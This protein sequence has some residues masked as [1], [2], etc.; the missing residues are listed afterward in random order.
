M[1][2]FVSPFQLRHPCRLA[3]YWEEA[4]FQA[5]SVTLDEIEN[6]IGCI[7]V[8]VF[9]N[10]TTLNEITSHPILLY[11]RT[12]IVPRNVLVGCCEPVSPIPTIQC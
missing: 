10:L 9:P 3:A 5:M 11:S 7:S 8:H 12:K 4:C 6:G 2:T 1:V